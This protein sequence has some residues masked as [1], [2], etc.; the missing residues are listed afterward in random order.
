MTEAANALPLARGSEPDS[1]PGVS[2]PAW[3]LIWPWIGVVC[4]LLGASLAHFHFTR[5][6]R[7]ANVFLFE[8]DI[9]AIA[10]A[11]A[12]LVVWWLAP[13]GKRLAAAAPT[14]TPT[15]SWRAIW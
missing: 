7:L 2:R 15:Q 14:W 13:F 8:Q 5:S 11:A 6:H 9:P 4:F 1:L 3:W 10:V 12:A